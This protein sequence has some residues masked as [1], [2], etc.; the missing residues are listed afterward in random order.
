MH[1]FYTHLQTHLLSR[2]LPTERRIQA[3]AEGRLPLGF[4]SLRTASDCPEDEVSG[5]SRSSAP[6]GSSSL[7]SAMAGSAALIPLSAVDRISGDVFI[8]KR[9]FSP[10]SSSLATWLAWASSSSGSSGTLDLIE[11]DID[12][13][14]V[15]ARVRGELSEAPTCPWL[16]LEGVQ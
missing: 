5:V 8:P 16:G 7:P 11:E 9:V 10:S 13:S 4:P 2:L 14:L 1:T 6:S 12:E 15:I 3:G